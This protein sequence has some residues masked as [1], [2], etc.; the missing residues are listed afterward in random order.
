MEIPLNEAVR[1]IY[2]RVVVLV[3]SIDEQGAVNA[4]PYSWVAPVSFSPPLIY[5]GIQKR[6][7]QTMK[8]IRAAGEFVVN[9][10]TE[11]IAQ[12]AV[13]CEGKKFEYGKKLQAVGLQTAESEK[14]KV[15]RV[16]EAQVVLECRL[17]EIIEAKDADHW[18]VIG[19]IVKAEKLAKE[20]KIVM[21]VEGDEFRGIGKKIKLKRHLS[22]IKKH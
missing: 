5:L 14:V 22:I 19:K 10:V 18:L 21:H 20:P 11:E 1:L 3:T 6:E 12:K 9:V 17:N 7:T 8:N 15:P 16:K 2:P 4:A 13:N